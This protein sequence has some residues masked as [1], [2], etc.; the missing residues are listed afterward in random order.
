MCAAFKVEVYLFVVIIKSSVCCHHVESNESSNL[1]MT[2]HDGYDYT[3]QWLIWW[4]SVIMIAEAQNYQYVYLI[5]A[6][7][8]N[9]SDMCKYY[10]R[11]FFYYLSTNFSSCLDCFGWYGPVWLWTTLKNVAQF[12]YYCIDHLIH[13]ASI[14]NYTSV[15]RGNHNIKIIA[16]GRP[17]RLVRNYWEIGEKRRRTWNHK[18]LKTLLREH[19]VKLKIISLYI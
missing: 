1:S 4:A 7:F 12:L 16:G 3:A 15:L 11:C 6:S 13:F 9:T 8:G 19:M 5:Y 14:K 2:V 18:Q 17:T 10:D